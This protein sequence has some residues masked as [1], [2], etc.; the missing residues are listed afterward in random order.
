MQKTKTRIISIMT[1]LAIITLA[2]CTTTWLAMKEW[3]GR[4][5]N[6]L[7]FDRGK[8]DEVESLNTGGRVHIWYSERTVKGEVKT[9]TRKFYTRNDGHG[10]VIIDTKYSGCLFLMAK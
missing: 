1:L 4:S 6:D 7:Y 8:A 10:E 9:C 3:E 2:G 5:I